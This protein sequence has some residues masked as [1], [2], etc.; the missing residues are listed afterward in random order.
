MRMV[1]DGP[2]HASSPALWDIGRYVAGLDIPAELIWG[3]ND[4]ILARGLPVMRKMFPTASVTET[5]AGH[6]LQ[7]EVP[8]VIAAAVRGSWMRC[9]KSEQSF[10]KSRLVAFHIG[11]NTPWTRKALNSAP[12]QRSRRFCVRTLHALRGDGG[13]WSNRL[14]RD[15]P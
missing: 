11:L 6:F 13:C 12:H 15:T 2:D 5:E 3:M 14:R 7:E 4:P 1:A 8:E 10:G 9:R